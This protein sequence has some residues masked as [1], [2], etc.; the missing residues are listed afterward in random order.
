VGAAAIKLLVT[1]RFIKNGFSAT[2]YKKLFIK[3]RERPMKTL[4]LL[5]DDIRLLGALQSDIVAAVRQLMQQRVPG[6]TEQ[7]KY[8][9]ILFSGYA[10]ADH[11]AVD[12]TGSQH[13][14]AFGGV[15][16][17]QQHVSVEFSHG[18]QISDPY[19]LLQGNGKGRR[20]LKL[21]TLADVEN[22]QLA[23]YIPLALAAAAK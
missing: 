3:S 20:H 23:Q 22:S 9:G 19:G 2:V 4:T 15:F 12:H 18:A 6:L 10:G 13:T 21:F 11:A 17:Y 1:S 5:L 16:A 7:V 14:V 8:G